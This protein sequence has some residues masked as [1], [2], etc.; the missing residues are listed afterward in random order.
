MPV[1][2]GLEVMPRCFSC[3]VNIWI[4]DLAETTNDAIRI[5]SWETDVVGPLLP[6][7]LVFM[8]LALQVA[9]NGIRDKGVPTGTAEDNAIERFSYNL[10]SNGSDGVQSSRTCLPQRPKAGHYRPARPNSL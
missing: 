7:N 8:C 5:E 1:V 10:L 2:S 6:C 3:L 9:G 4:V